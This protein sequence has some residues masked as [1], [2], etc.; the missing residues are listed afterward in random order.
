MFS[1]KNITRLSIMGI[2]FSIALS[3]CSFNKPQGGGDKQ[4]VLKWV[5]GGPSMQEDAEKV[6]EQFNVELQKKL[7]NTKVEFDLI[8]MTD[9]A[10]KWK[11]MSAS[12][13]QMDIVWNGWMIPFGLTARG[14]A[15]KPLDELLDKSAPEL[16]KSLPD[17]VWQKVK[18]D[19]KIYA[20]P[21]Y[22]QMSSHRVMFVN[23]EMADKYL[24]YAAMEKVFEANEFMTTETYGEI[25]K[26]LAALKQ[27][28]AINKGV[29]FLYNLPQKGYE[30]ILY[31]FY[32]KADTKDY[33]VINWFK[34]PEFKLYMKTKRDWFEKGYI[35]SDVLSNQDIK[36]DD[37]KKDGS[38]LWVA[39]GDRR[40]EESYSK[41]C[42][43]PVAVVSLEKNY[44]VNSGLSNTNS[45]IS[46]N[47]KDDE[48]AIKLL[49][50]INTKEGKELYNTLSFGI[51]GQHYQKVSDNKIEVFEGPGGTRANGSTSM[52]Y[53]LTNWA[54]GNTFNSYETQTD[55]PGWK[56]YVLTEADA[57]AK[58][59]PINGFVFNTDPV[60]TE[61]AQLSAIG[62]EYVDILGSGA[63]ANYEQ[64]YEEFI[65][66]TNLAGSEKIQAEMQ[67]QLDEWLKSNK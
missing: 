14:G 35:R 33:K 50:L 62:K 63:L 11:L 52:K 3:G 64:S 20:V 26:Y 16:K 1:K 57:K 21:N 40:N 45:A 42:N 2:A 41:K 8:S 44:T 27:N 34:T 7:P 49:Q 5:L 23:K 9:F 28:N 51:E 22:Q 19:G 53:G 56:E 43:F 61:M 10:E 58:I 55:V 66:K 12:N 54:I 48:R 4:T 32:I 38:V 18:V 47:C 6:W 17:W 36:Q 13:E 15:Y 31:D 24:D 25:E 67:R 37:G 30:Q 65:K 29:G 60:K 59:S 46:K 39:N